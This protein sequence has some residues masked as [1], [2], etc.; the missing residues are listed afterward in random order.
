MAMRVLKN[1]FPIYLF[2]FAMVVMTSPAQATQ[3]FRIGQF[4]DWTAYTSTDSGQLVCFMT[5]K[6]KLSQGNY[7]RRGQVFSFITHRKA[8][9]TH[10]V[11]SF[12][13]GYDHQK[14][15][16]VT[17]TID[18][19]KQFQLF[20]QGDT[21]WGKDA[22]TDRKLVNAIRSGN[23]MVVTGTSSRGTSTIDTY[24]LRGTGKAYNAI[25][26]ACK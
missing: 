13:A 2:A 7:T 15:S 8:D 21:A 1:K 19:N 3:P 10:D 18:K 22:A 5:S 20:T 25:T 12:I 4:H 11:V 6:P 24:S 9:R 16:D 14:Q 23:K 26:K 17:V